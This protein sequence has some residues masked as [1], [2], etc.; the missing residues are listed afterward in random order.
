MDAQRATADLPAVEH[1]VVSFGER[2]T[3]IGL[4]Q[5]LV[6]VFRRGEWMVAGAPGLGLIVEFEHREVDNP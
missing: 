5:G 3:R 4:E 6:A 1:D 2:V